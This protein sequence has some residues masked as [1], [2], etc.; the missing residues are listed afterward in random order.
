[1]RIVTEN[2]QLRRQ[3]E[4][5]VALKSNLDFFSLLW[6]QDILHP[7][8]AYVLDAADQIILR[9][10][11]SK[12][13]GVKAYLQPLFIRSLTYLGSPDQSVL[14]ELVAF[15]GKKKLLHLNLCSGPLTPANLKMGKYQSLTLGKSP[16]SLKDAYSEN[17][18]RGLKKAKYLIVKD[19]DY[20]AFHRFF[21]QQ[22]G[23]NLGSL[24]AAAWHRLENLVAAASQHEAVICLGAFDGEQLLAAGLF[25]KWDKGL[26]FIKGTLNEAGKKNGALVFLIDSVIEKFS[27]SHEVLDFIGS[28]Q[29]GIASFYRKFGAVDQQYSILKGRLPFV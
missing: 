29:E 17:V 25:I 10:P 12:K 16:K 7:Q 14:S 24:N 21:I 2:H 8:W 11:V 13:F 26:Y 1:M 20:G 27:A 23:E 9:I 18:K 4:Q 15:L 22:K 5:I 3:Y 28:N 19:L 6:V